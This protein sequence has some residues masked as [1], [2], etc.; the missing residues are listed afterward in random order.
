MKIQ[1][2]EK[3]KKNENAKIM[4]LISFNNIQNPFNNSTESEEFFKNIIK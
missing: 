3:R 4:N 1:R 2:K